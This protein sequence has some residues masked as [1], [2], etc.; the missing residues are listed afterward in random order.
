MD[1]HLCPFADY[2]DEDRYAPSWDA[3]GYV[4]DPVHAPVRLLNLYFNR[5]SRPLRRTMFL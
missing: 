1:V 4:P 5:S 3:R 2:T